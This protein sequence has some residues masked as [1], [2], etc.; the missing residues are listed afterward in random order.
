MDLNTK[1]CD[2]HAVRGWLG[3]SPMLG[4]ALRYPFCSVLGIDMKYRGGYS[5]GGVN[6]GEK[7]GR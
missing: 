5:W 2:H 6:L 1:G 3:L 4:D 7:E